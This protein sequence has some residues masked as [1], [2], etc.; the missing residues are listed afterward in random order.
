MINQCILFFSGRVAYGVVT[1]D[2]WKGFGAVRKA[3]DNAYTARRPRDK[4]KFFE[5]SADTL[6]QTKKAIENYPSKRC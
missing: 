5:K 3:A 2:T 4:V 1:L 6:E